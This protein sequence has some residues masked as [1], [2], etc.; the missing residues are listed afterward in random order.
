MAPRPGL[1]PGTYGLTAHFRAHPSANLHQFSHGLDQGTS[2]GFGSAS[3]STCMLSGIN[4]QVVV[5]T[6][7][8]TQVMVVVVITMYF[9]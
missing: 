8:F 1:E 3:A 4:Q 2:D 7:Y 6:M 9:I 5:I